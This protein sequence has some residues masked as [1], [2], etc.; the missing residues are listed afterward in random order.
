M[1]EIPFLISAFVTLFVVIDPIGTAPL[2]LALTQGMT[3]KQRRTVGLRACFIAALLLMAFAVAGE[4]FLNFIGIS[5]PAFQIAGGLLLF[6]TALDMLFDRRSERRQNHADEGTGNL[7]D[8]PSVFPLAMP[9]IAGPGAMATM[10]LLINDT[11]GTWEGTALISGVMLAVIA[12]VLL[13][14]LAAAPLERMLRRTGTMVL[15]RLFGLLLSAL[16]VQFVL[17]GATALGILPSAV[18]M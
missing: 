4:D 18:P 15:T 17:N 8:D 16:S 1:L 6:L 13:A 3:A 2:F 5:M 10:V 7:A 9:L 12:L 11:G 14:F